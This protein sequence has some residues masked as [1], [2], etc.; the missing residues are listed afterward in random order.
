MKCNKLWLS[1][2]WAIGILMQPAKIKKKSLLYLSN[3][4]KNKVVMHVYPL[5]MW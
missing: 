1:G 2:I 4:F 5:A 3:Y